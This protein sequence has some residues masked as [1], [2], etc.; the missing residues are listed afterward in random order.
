MS[1]TSFR[2]SAG[3]VLIA[4]LCLSLPASALDQ[5]R[6]APGILSWLQEWMD[7]VWSVVL[8]EAPKPSPT[9]VIEMDS[10][11]GGERGALIDPN[12]G[13]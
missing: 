6:R 11:S 7:A 13:R 5:P 8:P 2:L 9:L 10:N 3:F 1:R 4:L 12:G